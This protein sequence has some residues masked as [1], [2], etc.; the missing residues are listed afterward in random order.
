MAIDPDTDVDEA[1]PFV[2][3]PPSIGDFLGSGSRG[4]VIDPEL[5]KVAPCVAFELGKAGEDEERLVFVQGVVGPLDDEQ[6]AAYCDTVAVRELSP[7]L[8]TR[9][10]AFRDAAA[11]CAI[12]EQIPE[13]GADHLTSHLSCMSRELRA[14][15]E[16]L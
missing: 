13:P 14:R 10:A 15:G 3:G 1:V 11:V 12:E 8:Q 2:N 6:Q 7:E 16:K 4:V 5:A 9:L